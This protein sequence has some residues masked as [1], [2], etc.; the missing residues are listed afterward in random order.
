MED[1]VVVQ[2]KT[3]FKV[4]YFFALTALCLLSGFAGFNSFT[5]AIGVLILSLKLSDIADAIRE[6]AH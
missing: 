2:K 1:L 5:I 4:W 3:S 6:S